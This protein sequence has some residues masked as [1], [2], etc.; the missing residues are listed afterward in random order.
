MKICSLI[1][2]STCQKETLARDRSTNS[3]RPNKL[4]S[5]TGLEKWLTKNEKKCRPPIKFGTVHLIKSRNGQQDQ[6]HEAEPPQP[7]EGRTR[8]NHSPHYASESSAHQRARVS[9][10]ANLKNRLQKRRVGGYYR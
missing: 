7:Q 9:K 4:K 2:S 1:T 8:N 6:G 3:S 5:P 10:Q